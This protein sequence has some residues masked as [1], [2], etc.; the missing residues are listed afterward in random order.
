MLNCG[1]NA[2]T[3]LNYEQ[4]RTY[5]NEQDEDDEDNAIP[6]PPIIME[7]H[8]GKNEIVKK[9]NQKCVICFEIPG[10]YAFC[11]IGNECFCEN[12]YASTTVEMLKCAVCR[13]Q[14]FL[15]ALFLSL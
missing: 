12:S 10:V 13:T 3:Q 7:Y 15:A 6:D 8:N 9:S 11:Q 5:Y 4:F 2:F 1:E 14:F